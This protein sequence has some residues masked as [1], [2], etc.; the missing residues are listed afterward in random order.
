MALAL[1]LDLRNGVTAT[2]WRITRAE[3][4]GLANSTRIRLSGYLSEA[5]RNDGKCPVKN[6]DFYWHGENN[7]ITPTVLMSGTAYIA[8]YNK[9]KAEVPSIG[10]INPALFGEATDA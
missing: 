6:Y 10:G 8:C 1:E 7:P 9:V 5:A 3:I 4:D 2:Y